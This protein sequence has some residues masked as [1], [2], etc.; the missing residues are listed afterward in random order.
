MSQPKENR[1][2][3]VL[4]AV[5]DSLRRAKVGYMIIGAWALAVWGRPRATMDLDF[6]VMLEEDGL[7]HLGER[8]GGEG[9]LV[10]ETWAKWNPML[11]GLQLRMQCQGIM[12]DLMRP[13]DA[14]D[15]QAF[16]RRKKK[17]LTSR[18][19]W[20]VAPDDFILQKIKTGRPRDFEDALSV[21]ERSRRIIDQVYLRRWASRLGLRE[22]LDFLLN[23]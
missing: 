12:V 5:I 15:Q 21:V 1:L 2:L 13:R 8:L 7:G 6:L 23:E 16:A 9:L 18:T 10:D 11:R 4:A 20:V 22:E 19:C 3:E 17:R 14:H